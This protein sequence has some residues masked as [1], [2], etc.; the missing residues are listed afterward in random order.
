[1]KI[2]VLSHMYPQ[3]GYEHYGIFVHEPLREL[4]K[5]GHEIK[6]VA[7][8]P[9]TVPGLGL[10]KR[11][12]RRIAGIP[13]RRELDGI[14][15]AH[16]RYLF[17]PRRID[18]A[19]SGRRMA[20]AVLALPGLE[21]HD[22]LH[23]HGALPDGAAAR[24]IAAALSL[25]YLVTSHGSDVLRMAGWSRR[26]HEE[27]RAALAGAEQVLVPSGA[28][29]RR[30]EE[31][32]LPCDRMTVLPNGYARELFA[33]DAPPR[34]K[35]GP[36]RVLAVAHF[37]PSKRLDLLLRAVAAVRECGTRLE[38]QIVGYGPE[39]GAL[40]SLAEQLA[41]PVRWTRSLPRPELAEAMRAAQIFAL[42][43]EGES[44]GIVYLEAMASGLAVLAVAGEG[45]AD[46]ITDGEDG[47]LLPAGD[48]AA[49]TDALTRLA[50][51]DQ[52]RRRLGEAAIR[53]ASGLDW[54]RHAARLESIYEETL[55][56]GRARE[57]TTC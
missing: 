38:L 43:A 41:L 36:L 10:V 45:I 5:L 31:R 22:L 42:P 23:A 25:P 19:G 28:A 1:V 50:G 16:P 32:G 34:S 52:L 46:V 56:G 7:P 2:L 39:E 13:G 4:R 51:D 57:G 9:R 14:P 20:R 12:W 40:R 30:A 33:T 21:G 11:D 27:I 37:M 18:V 15:V 24:R 47:L 6:V 35:G 44:F 54:A 53:R 49:L 17:W 3:P 29:R 8:I 26:C 48:G 55:R